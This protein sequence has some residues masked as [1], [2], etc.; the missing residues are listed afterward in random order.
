LLKHL[1]GLERPYRGKII[2]EGL[3]LAKA[4]DHE[5]KQVRKRFGV[6]FQSGALLGSMT[7]I[8]N[9]ELPITEHTELS[10]DLVELLARTK[11]NMVHLS[12]FE[13]Y[14]PSELSGGM[15]K[16]AGLAR[17]MSLD[18]E[19]LFFDEP[20]AGLDPVTSVELDQTIIQ[21]NHSLGTTMV[22]V[23]HELPSIFTIAH[24]VIMLDAEDKTI[25][26][27]GVP[28]ELKEHSSDPRV[29]NFFNREAD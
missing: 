23:S 26:A 7:L 25:I 10:P 17:A 5:L 6:L 29:H 22:I 27:R 1:I 4:S 12:G 21:L 20:S 14:L 2:I 3:D 8:E 16:R 13:E 9:V 15:R 18:P 24:R 11:L 28:Q 19:I